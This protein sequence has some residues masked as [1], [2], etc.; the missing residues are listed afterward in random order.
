MFELMRSI[1]YTECLLR[2]KR[3]AEWIYPMGFFV[4]V[5]ALFYLTLAPDTVFLA[6]HFTSLVWI[7]LFLSI[8][9]TLADFFKSETEDGHLT[10]WIFTLRA[11]T[12]FNIKMLAAWT[13]TVLPLILLTPILGIMFHQS[14][15]VIL[16]LVFN[17]MI[18][19]PILFMIGAL[20]AALSLGLHHA[21]LLSGFLLLTL[22]LPILLLSVL[23]SE[24]AAP[25]SF[26]IG[27]TLLT[28]TFLP[29]VIVK[30]L[31]LIAGD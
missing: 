24:H 29:M 10:L 6:M 15:D 19:S 4:I 25:I 18:A 12:L 31:R 14:S 2:T 11:L 9:I 13:T 8:L 30:V 5:M 17:L 22:G 16:F 27:V 20:C 26:L 1:F 23:T 21:G 3:T 7:T 28:M